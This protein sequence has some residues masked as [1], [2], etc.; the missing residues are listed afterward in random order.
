MKKITKTTLK[1]WDACTDGYKRFCKL[2]PKGADLKTA[3][4]GLI[5]DGH[6]DWANW[7][8][9]KCKQDEK[10]CD[11]TTATAGNWGTATAG[12]KGTATA[13]N[14]GTAT[15]G[16]EGTATA[17]NWGTATA[18]DEGTATAGDEGTATAGDEGCIS[19][20]YFSPK[21]EK[22]LR[23]IGVIGENGLKPNT[24]YKLEENGKFVEVNNDT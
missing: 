14:W 11:Q 13:G 15:A 3:S 1:N 16:D 10:Y 8:W 2:F 17:G 12:Y 9:S 5:N 24:P 23:K 20:L 7:L 6:P 18:G 22:Y 19:I 21:K 4:G